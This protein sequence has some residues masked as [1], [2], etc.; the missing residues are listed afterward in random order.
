M[1]YF[2]TIIATNKAYKHSLEYFYY[3]IIIMTAIS[4]DTNSNMDRIYLLSLA[5]T[6]TIV[7]CKPQ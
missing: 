5:A 1:F 4:S 6:Y 2:I 7:D 3:I